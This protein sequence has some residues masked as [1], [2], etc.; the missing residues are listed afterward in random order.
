MRR[1]RAI[2]ITGGNFTNQGAYLMLCATADAIR[3]EFN[4]QPVISV[5][6]GSERE[7]RWLGLDSLAW[8]PRIHLLLMGRGLSQSSFLRRR[9]PVMLGSDVDAVFDISGFVFSDEWSHLDLDRRARELAMW[10]EAGVPVYVLPQAFGP[11]AKTAS[12]ARTVVKTSRV[13]F[14]R[15]PTSKKYL[16][17]VDQVESSKIVDGVDFT[18]GVAPESL[19]GFEHLEGGAAI[20]P[21][22][23]ILSRGTESARQKYLDTLSFWIQG[24]KQRGTTPFLLCHEGAQDEAIGRSALAQPGASCELVSGL[25]GRQSKYLLSMSRF[26]VSGRFHALVSSL[27]TGV[28]AVS[29]GWSHKYRHLAEEFGVVDLISDPFGGARE[30]GTVIDR[31]YRDEERIRGS[32]RTESERQLVRISEMWETIA[33]DLAECQTDVRNGEEKPSERRGR[34]AE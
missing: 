1:R 17:E 10:S 4:S 22:W 9:L 19:E 26:A 11:F 6:T 13:V 14:V 24:F 23:N 27:S 34:L 8:V 12:S 25:N 31:L 16:E 18:V 15:D 29:H 32:L 33:A 20:V 30:V 7:K 2:L 28:P 21:N 5:Q 3:R